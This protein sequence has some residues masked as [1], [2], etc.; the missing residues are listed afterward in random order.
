MTE[1]YPYFLQ[2]WGYQAWNIADKSPVGIETVHKATAASITR[3]NESFFGVRF[4][5][6]EYE[7]NG[8]LKIT[9]IISLSPADIT[10]EIKVG[11][12]LSSVN[13]VKIDGAK[14]LD[15]LLENKVGKRVELEISTNAD[16]SNK[17]RIVLKPIS[18]GAEKNLL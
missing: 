14:N 5:R 10:K 11:D 9:E 15:E 2:E 16:G 18:T 4:D 13:N 7:T 12:Y 8:R 17:R 1:C 6:L 3:L